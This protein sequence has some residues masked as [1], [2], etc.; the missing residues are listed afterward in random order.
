MKL[1]KLKRKSDGKFYKGK[2]KFTSFGTYFRIQQIEGN[3]NWVK[4]TG[5]DLELIVYDIEEYLK[6][7]ISNIK[8]DE[9][10]EI[11]LR[12]KAINSILNNE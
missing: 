10:K 4:S 11:L 9:M 7:D 5:G 8:L 1:Y 2:S 6:I 3:L 12:D